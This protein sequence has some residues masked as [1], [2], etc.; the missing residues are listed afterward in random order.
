[1][2][3][4]PGNAQHQGTRKEQ[5]DS[6]GFSDFADSRFVRHGGV[7]AALADGMGGMA[8]GKQ[9]SHAAL[10]GMLESYMSKRPDEAI[11]AALY[12]AIICANDR[13]ASISDGAEAGGA[14]VGTTMAACVVHN[15]F[16]YWICAGDS[17]IY[18]LRNDALTQINTDHTY[19]NELMKEFAA[20]DITKEEIYNH[21]DRFALTSYLGMRQIKAID[22]NVRP[23]PLSVGDSV[24]LCSDGLYNSLTPAEM[25]QAITQDPQASAECLVQ[26][27]ISKQRPNQ[28]NTSAAVLSC[29]RVGGTS[30]FSRF[31]RKLASLIVVAAMFSG[32][33]SATVS[34]ADNLPIKR[35]KDSTVRIID[36]YN[37]KPIGSG[38]G[39]VIGDGYYVVTNWHVVECIEKGCEP[40]VVLGFEDVR[41]VRIVRHSEIKDIAILNLSRRLDK[42]SVELVL[43]DKVEDAHIVYAIGFPG[44]ADYG[45]DKATFLEPKISKGI[46]SAK[47]TTP[48]GVRMYQT[49]ATINPGNSGGPMFNDKGYVIGINSLKIVKKD[50]QGIGWAIQVD[51]L[52]SELRMAGV[53]YSEGAIGGRQPEQTP[54]PELSQ[55]P[56]PAQSPAQSPTPQPTPAPTKTPRPPKHTPAPKVQPDNKTNYMAGAAV[57][58]AIAI[59]ICSLLLMKRR[60]GIA[61][62]NAAPP[63]AGAQRPLLIGLSGEYAGAKIPLLTE[64]VAIGRDPHKSNLVFTRSSDTISAIHCKVGYDIPAKSF[65]IEDCGSKNG[66]FLRSGQRLPANQ[67]YYVGAGSNFYL[68]DHINMFELGFER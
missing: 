35:M 38:S 26:R 32:P 64:Q 46:I 16:L 43:S 34:V 59:V 11:I 31:M 45:M 42:P 48:E 33:F 23:Y 49:D 22:R 10:Q 56:T 61:P 6:V 41:G 15:S 66:T 39:F 62:V 65:Y 50:V 9:T 57:I 18:L 21:P 8:N 52:V 68:S 54:N 27:A 37:G 47:V 5:Q 24:I 12:R 3:V 30:F 29:Q 20:G 36:F 63:A 4:I 28:D 14:M 13:A 55:T 58:G 44:A 53:M 2:S 1:M 17:R 67:R 51:E 19:E 7:M 25:R 60:K 40:K